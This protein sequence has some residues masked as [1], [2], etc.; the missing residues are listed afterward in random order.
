MILKL[1]LCFHAIGFF[2]KLNDE[3]IECV[4]NIDNLFFIKISQL[5]YDRART[6]LKK[7]LHDLVEVNNV[8]YFYS[9]SYFIVYLIVFIFVGKYMD[10]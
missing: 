10:Y 3:L 6:I 4:E 8:S 7:D 2:E 9:L 5:H 1:S